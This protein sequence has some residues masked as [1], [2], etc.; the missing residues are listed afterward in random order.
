MEGNSIKE[1]K[2]RKKVIIICLIC[3]TAV[4]AAL[5]AAAA[6]TGLHTQD[7]TVT[8]SQ[9]ITVT[10]GKA[11]P[12]MSEWELPALRDG[13]YRFHVE[14]QRQQPGFVSG[15]VIKDEQ[16]QVVFAVT[17]DSVAADS[18]AVKLREE[19]YH[20]EMHYL[21]NEQDYIRFIS[22]YIIGTGT[23]PTTISKF[24]PAGI[25]GDGSCTMNYAIGAQTAVNA[26]A[27]GIFTGAVIGIIC[28]VLLATLLKTD[29][30]AKCK[31]DERQELVRGRGFKYGFFTLLI[32]NGLIALLKGAGVDLYAETEVAVGINCFIGIGVYAAYCIW[33]EGYFGLNNNK[34]GLMIAFAVI[35]A[36]NLF[37]SAVFIVKGAMIQ[38]G[39]LTLYS[40][41]LFCGL[42]FVV[43]FVTML[44]K[45]ICKDREDE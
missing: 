21:T 33:N 41:N 4:V 35:A 20:V 25:G 15:C 30:S 44:L 6:V 7:M 9:E 38:N 1:T 2:S 45:K 24:E 23:K 18:A 31:Y 11:E 16:G 22:D 36:V 19:T 42:L 26:V 43:I 3:L 10:D 34:K 12:E 37:N 8:F 39:K 13:M 5:A 28:T 14:W 27:I 40:F 17:G 32:C 29:K